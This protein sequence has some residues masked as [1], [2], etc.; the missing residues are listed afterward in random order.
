MFFDLRIRNN[1]LV[2]IASNISLLEFGDQVQMRWPCFMPW[3]CLHF[4]S[5][6]S[7]EKSISSESFR[8]SFHSP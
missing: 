1:L 5:H 3:L 2:R 8:I 4:G 6:W 7:N